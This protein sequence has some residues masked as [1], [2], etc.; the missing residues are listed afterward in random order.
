MTAW[1]RS[2]NSR[3]EAYCSAVPAFRTAPAGG[4][5]SGEPGIR[6]PR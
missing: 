5:G 2:V 4:T 1:A 3:T 6:A